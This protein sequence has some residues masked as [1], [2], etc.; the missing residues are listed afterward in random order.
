MPLE[1]TLLTLN[2][3]VRCGKVRY[4]GASN[5]GGWQLQKVVEVSKYMG[6]NSFI[7]LQVG[8]S[9][10]EGSS[11]QILPLTFFSEIVFG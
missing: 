4:L 5:F 9:Q 11:P 6:L 7:A 10:P 1:E 2:D 3:L 8:L